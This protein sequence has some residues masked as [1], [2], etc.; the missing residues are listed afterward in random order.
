MNI[1]Q[2]QLCE[3]ERYLQRAQLQSRDALFCQESYPAMSP[4]GISWFPLGSPVVQKS[5]A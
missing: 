2:L 1:E 5:S 3:D 4:D